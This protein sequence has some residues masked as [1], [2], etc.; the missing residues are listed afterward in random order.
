MTTAGTENSAAAALGTWTL[1]TSNIRPSFV[2]VSFD[3]AS[4]EIDGGRE[5]FVKVNEDHWTSDDD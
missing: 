1:L 5:L 4:V 3:L 2:T